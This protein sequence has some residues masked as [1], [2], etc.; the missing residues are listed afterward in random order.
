M[1]NQPSKDVSA[2]ARQL[3]DTRTRML[4]HIIA[5]QV[6][7]TMK[8]RSPHEWFIPMLPHKAER[9]ET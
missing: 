2:R 8:A 3:R 6:I 4:A 1:R 9:F 5:S 7:E